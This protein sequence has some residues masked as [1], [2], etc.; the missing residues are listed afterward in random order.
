MTTSKWFCKRGRGRKNN[1]RLSG[2]THGSP[3]SPKNLMAYDGMPGL[4]IS[5]FSFVCG[6]C[7]RHFLH[8]LHEP[9][10]LAEMPWSLD[11]IGSLS[12]RCH[13]PTGLSLGDLWLQ[14]W[15]QIIDMGTGSGLGALTVA[16]TSWAL[17][18][19]VWSKWSP[20]NDVQCNILQSG[21]MIRQKSSKFIR[22]PVR[23]P[24]GR[25]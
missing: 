18:F 9:A 5:L 19:D 2:S 4:V 13:E 1:E 10:E 24:V 12:L 20:F 23:P 7:W 21:C 22:C 14:G 15:R 8:F 3:V 17:S 11:L 6:S 16:E 25:Q